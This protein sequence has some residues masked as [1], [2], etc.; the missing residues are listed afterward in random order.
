MCLDKPFELIGRTT[1]S[2][3]AAGSQV[4]HQYFFVRTKHFGS[5]THEMDPTHYNNISFG[6]GSPLCQSQTIAHKVGYVLN[7][8]PLVVMTQHYGV[9][10]FFQFLDFFPEIIHNLLYLYLFLFKI[11]KIHV[12][13]DRRLIV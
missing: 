2:Q 10:L 11:E 8:A 9:F 12:D 3:R 4:G 7:I 1:V 13:D 6:F 5:F